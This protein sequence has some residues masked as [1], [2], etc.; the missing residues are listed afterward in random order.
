MRA[1]SGYEA[2]RVHRCVKHLVFFC[3]KHEGCSVVVIT[4]VHP[5]HHDKIPDYPRMLSNGNCHV[6]GMG[7][8]LSAVGRG[9][10][11]AEKCTENHR[12]ISCCIYSS[13]FK[14][15]DAGYP[16]NRGSVWLPSYFMLR[17]LSFKLLC[18]EK[19]WKWSTHSM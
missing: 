6:Q 11:V 15:V 17:L 7:I 12:H 4:F 13:P 10:R 16:L 9:D 3:C 5:K 19:P 1:R 14:G 8:L 2:I 18:H